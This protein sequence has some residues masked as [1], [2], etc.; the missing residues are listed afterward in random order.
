V[1]LDPDVTDVYGRPVPRITYNVHPR[2]KA[3]ADF[4][5][6]KLRAIAVAAGANTVMPPTPMDS[7]QRYFD[8]E[9]K[10]LLGTARMG[11]DPATSVCDPWGRLHEVENV[12]I[13][14]GSTWPTSAAF[15][16]VLTQQALA[17]RTAAYLLKPDDPA[18]VI[19]TEA[20]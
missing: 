17:Y 11:T 5:A 13:C 8:I 18:S 15:N 2:D 12:W 4:Y 10:H 1:E 19:P 3:M 20:P 9:S 6:E 16:P 7:K 14:D